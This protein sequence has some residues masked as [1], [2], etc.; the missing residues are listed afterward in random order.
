MAQPLADR[1]AQLRSQIC[2]L[3][4]GTQHDATAEASHG[5][6]DA[7]DVS[8]DG[9]RLTNLGSSVVTRLARRHLSRA[10]TG[11]GAS[12]YP[13]QPPADDGAGYAAQHWRDDPVVGAPH[14][15]TAGSLSQG[16]WHCVRVVRRPSRLVPAHAAPSAVCA[17]AYVLVSTCLY[18]Q[19]RACAATIERARAPCLRA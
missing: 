15:H 1:L 2:D 18:L 10:P 13:H 6:E 12:V 19:V 3:L 14:N 5:R 4:P 8:L 16:A 7:T 17:C 9:A 11:C